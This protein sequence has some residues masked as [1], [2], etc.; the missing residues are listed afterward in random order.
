MARPPKPKQ[1][2][3]QTAVRTWLDSLPPNLVESLTDQ[4]PTTTTT[5][6][7]NNT[8]TTTD[9][10]Q[11]LLDRAPKRWVV[12]EPMVLLP[13]GSFSSAP[14][15]ALL[16]SLTPSQKE[17]LW[18][19]ILHQISPT[20]FKPPLTHLAINEPIP[21]HLSNP[22]PQIPT[23]T[24]TNQ[25]QDQATLS[26]PS[27]NL[28]R[29]PTSLHPLH[30]SFGTPSPATDFT[31]ALWVT[32]KQNNLIQTWAPLHT[33][34]SRGNIKEKA[35]LL[36][37][38]NPPSTQSS[39]PSSPPSQFPHRQITLQGRGK[40]AIDLYA[41]IGYF[42]LPL[43]SLGLRVVCWELNPWS[44]EGLRRGAAANGFSVRV[45]IPSP[46]SSS[47]SSPSSTTSTTAGG[48]EVDVDQELADWLAGEEQIVVVQEDN[49]FAAGRV[50]RLRGLLEVVHVNCGFLPSSEGVWKD[51]WG[52]VGGE[53][54]G[55][56][57]LHENVGVEGIE[58]RREVLQGL[59]DRWG[60]EKDDGKEGRVEHV[61]LVKTF[62]PGVWHCVFDVFIRRSSKGLVG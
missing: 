52:M 20:N 58:A 55:W 19:A 10:K 34:F 54:N 44:V 32:T 53:E 29:A 62:A 56:L 15:P 51:A 9:T 17:P 7:T 4:L 16:S 47:S 59:L 18:T 36:S 41:G 14:W 39:S 26:N 50:A 38:H 8:T 46:S 61:E 5:T 27:E 49:R 42:T 13:S 43:A 45:V 35:R 1:N 33:M 60:E 57:H 21:L 30:G 40:Y 3:V 48:E 31:S 25:A 37:F 12:Y 28:L 23:P 6:D 2:P 24:T 11:I 22:P